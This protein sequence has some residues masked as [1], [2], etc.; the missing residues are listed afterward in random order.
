MGRGPREI[1]EASHLWAVQRAR[2]AS[3]LALAGRDKALPPLAERRELSLPGAAGP[4]AARLY[5][6]DGTA[7][8]APLLL[9]FHGGGFIVGDLDTYES[10]CIR[11]AAAGDLRVVSASYRLAP[12][13]H[14]PAQ[15]DDALSV[16]RAV[17]QDPELAAGR[18]FAVGGDSA[19][20]YLAASVA[21]QLTDAAPGSV[22]AQLLIYPLVHVEE[23]IWS[24]DLLR[25]TRALGWAAVK[26]IRAQIHDGVVEAP[27]LLAP[28]ALAA[29]PT[30]L[31]VGG[32]LDPVAVDA[33]PLADRLREIG[34]RVT[35]RA[36]PL[37][38]HGFAN[39]THVSAA[40]RGAVMEIGELIGAAARA[41]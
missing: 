27:S 2:D 20:G 21:K 15:L 14:F 31:V 28:D 16:A 6:A 18:P 10:L 38:V 39:L 19:G 7:A 11:L 4:L 25:H 3:R 40:I 12:E 29:I 13:H 5:R 35:F 37:F 33:G 34:A 32:P 30:V 24:A 17:A 36:H 23:E 22:L 41:R 26:Y 8:D 1:A 9:F